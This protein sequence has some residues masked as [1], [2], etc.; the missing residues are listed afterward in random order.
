MFSSSFLSMRFSTVGSTTDWDLEMIKPMSARYYQTII[1]F[2]VF[3]PLLLLSLMWINFYIK[4]FM[5]RECHTLR[6]IVSEEAT[7]SGLEIQQCTT[8]D[9]K[10][11]ITGLSLIFTI[12][13]SLFF[14]TENFQYRTDVFQEDITKRGNDCGEFTIIR[15]KVEIIGALISGLKG[16]RNNFSGNVHF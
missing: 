16:L 1:L 8:E 9:S 13:K 15:N 11:T 14:E 6:E 7:P 4:G 12:K 10:Y 2:S 3:S 5:N